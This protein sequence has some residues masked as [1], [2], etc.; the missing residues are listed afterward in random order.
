MLREET[1]DRALGEIGKGYAQYQYFFDHLNSP[2]WLDPLFRRGFFQKPPEPV[3]DE[4]YI[5]LPLWPESRYLVR[6]SHIV[7]A[8][9]TVLKI[10]LR[11]PDTENSR[12]Q[13]DIAELALSLPPA[14]SAGL[15]PQ[16]C[17]STKSPIKLLLPERVAKLVVHLAEGGQG[18]AALK[19]AR[20]ALALAADPRMADPQGE[21]SP[22]LPE[23]RSQF[24]D[25]YYA[26]IVERAVPALVNAVGLEA[27]QLFSELLN[28]AAQFSCKE[29]DA[30]DEDYFYIRHPAIEQG[31]SRDDIPSLLLC[32]T[33]DAAE[34][35]VASDRAH[36]DEVLAVFQERSWASFRR[37]EFHISRVFLEQGRVVAERVFENPE[38]LTR[39]SLSHEAVLLLKASFSSLSTERQ[40]QILAWMDAGPSDKSV[41]ERLE[42]VGE[43]V[44]DE[45]IRI[46]RNRRRRDHFSILEGQLPEPYQRTYEQLKVELGEPNP[47]E[48]IPVRSFGAISA[49]S[50]KSAEELAVM[51]VD[52][53]LGFL[54]SWAA[55]GGDIFAPTAE[56]LG[57][58]LT[59][60]VS[61]RPGDFADAARKFRTLDPTYVRCLFAGLDAAL[62]KGEKWD[63]RP[64]LEL[65]A[66]VG[67]QPR[68]IEGRKGGLMIADPDWGWT[69]DSI[70]ELLKTGFEG[71]SDRLSCEHRALV[72]GAL[73][74]LTDDPSPSLEDER[75]E[76]F[77]PAFLSINSTRGR[78]L[79]AV[80][81]Y[82][83]WVRKCADA[84]RKSREEPAVT[85]GAMPE[86]RDI[87]D[88]HLDVKRE[89]TL[90]IR[91]V[92][93]HQ[94]SSL[95]GL[96]WEWFRANV[97][98]ILPLGQSNSAYF[99]AAW[100]SFVVFNQPHDALLRGLM[101][102]Y[103]RAVA[104]VAKRSRMM[105]H[106]ESP[107]DR[108]AEHL[109]VYYWRGNLGFG[110][111]D[112][113]LDGFYAQ[114]PDELRG[115]AMWFIGRSVSSWDDGAPP[116]AFERLR[117]L[118][119]RR[120]KSAGQAAAV[121]VFAKEMANFGWW[122]TSKKFD[123]RWSIE[124]LLGTLQ[125]TK[126]TEAE[127]D[128]VK[129]LAELCPRY[130]T[131][132][133]SCLGLMI[134]GDREHWLLL[135]VEDD[136]RQMI[137]LA[138]ESSRPEAVESAGRL[139]ENLIARGHFGFR[140][141]LG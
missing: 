11:I 126:K 23:P 118:M 66:W 34:Q 26:R 88:G 70:I 127:M 129:R 119:E 55:P 64:V 56:G 17:G 48:R 130:P 80:L 131:E 67:G 39:P 27:V 37:L 42:F 114:A 51:R 44:T 13:D 47:P 10:A 25:W 99:N 135:G 65:A 20:A 30:R 74:P 50:P 112:R 1:V 90:T 92:Y 93:G 125:L 3:R 140:S 109:M 98:R 29:P 52:E 68:A 139:V 95:A 28:A 137:T 91:S 102:A 12:V 133:V 4:E 61:Q 73:A 82:A 128:V 106:P 83:R 116:E 9:E 76:R 84:Q 8:Q 53:L 121:T 100:E 77:D 81:D 108:L 15:V 31:K 136:A 101:P 134:E 6:M 75:G 94:L 124:T 117:D 58:A 105:R 21:E 72:W 63:W 36:F 132:C 104:E 45:K 78:A 85:L 5:R 2:A 120:L 96:D 19:L 33:R 16:V 40:R 41:R 14:L 22:L 123:D 35:L 24:K 46:V 89:P 38:I 69:R 86:V 113:L 32:A 115:H 71:G 97:E 62:K 7:E 49:Q 54:A 79:Y 43:P 60:V 57:G 103:Q 110:G 141:L 18:N 59:T 122:F 107:E 138:L 111:E 87:L